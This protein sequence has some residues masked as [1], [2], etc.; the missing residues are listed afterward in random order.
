M[1]GAD[2]PSAAIRVLV[3]DDEAFAR[4]NVTVLLRRDPDIGSVT[5]CG[6]GFD[7]IE[8]IR[9]SDPDLVFLDVQ[10]PVRWLRYAGN[11]GKRSAA[12]HHL[13]DGLR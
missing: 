11:P 1:A 10:M 5:E 6:S 8:E 13:C 12:H 7:A 3:V 4:R 2:K 9:K